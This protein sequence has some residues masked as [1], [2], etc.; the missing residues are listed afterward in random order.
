MNSIDIHEAF[1]LTS[2]NPLI[3][4]CTQ[5]GDGSL[6]LAPVSFFMFASFTPPMVA[7]AMGVTKNSGENFR[8]TGK[9][10][11]VTPGTVIAE[12]SMKYGTRSGRDTDKL[13]MWPV[14]LQTLDGTDIPV[15][16]ESRAAFAVS[17]DQVITTGDHYLYTCRVDKVYG[18]SSVDALYAWNGYSKLSGAHSAK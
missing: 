11:L 13:S 7:F 2:P 9:A 18:D 8:R 17:L 3:L 5:K 1:R 14:E 10:V 16:K 12:E 15:P 6:N 4:V